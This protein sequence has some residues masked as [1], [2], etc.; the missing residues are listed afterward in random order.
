MFSTDVLH[1]AARMRWS[2]AAFSSQQASQGAGGTLQQQQGG[3]PQGVP[4]GEHMWI[5][6][7]FKV[8]LVT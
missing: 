7:M 1:D 6:D 2:A 8:S 3:Q 4:A 5:A